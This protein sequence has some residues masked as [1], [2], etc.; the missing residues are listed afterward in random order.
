MRQWDRLSHRTIVAA[1]TMN[2][3]IAQLPVGD[4]VSP[5]DSGLAGPSVIHVGQLHTGDRSRLERRIGRLSQIK[6]R[7]VEEAEPEQGR[8]AVELT[9]TQGTVSLAALHL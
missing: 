2:L 6:M 5:E 7:E 8:C 4:R 9:R 1:I 3:R